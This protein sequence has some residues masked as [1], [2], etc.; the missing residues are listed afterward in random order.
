M[1]TRTA[2]LLRPRR[3]ILIVG[4]VIGAIV[5]AGIF[6]LL[7]GLRAPTAGLLGRGWDVSQAKVDVTVRPDA[8]V[9]VREQ[10]HFRVK[11]NAWDDVYAPVS[12]GKGQVD[13]VSLENV[14]GVALDDENHSTPLEVGRDVFENTQDRPGGGFRVRG[15]E[16]IDGDAEERDVL[17]EY[18]VRKAVEVY[19]DVVFVR[20]VVRSGDANAPLDR[21]DASVRLEAENGTTVTP[22]RSWVH[23]ASLGVETEDRSDA[24]TL[25]VKSIPRDEEIAISA[26][27]PREGAIASTDEAVVRKGDGRAQIEAREDRLVAEEG[28]GLATFVWTNQLPL[29]GLVLLLAL[30]ATTALVSVGHGIRRRNGVVKSDAAGHVPE[31]V[32]PATAFGL[33][34]LRGDE[35]TIVL[36]TL[37]DL[38]DRGFFTGRL[39][40]DGDL[41]LARATTRPVVEKLTP[42]ESAVLGFF[43]R[44][45]G[46]QTRGL[47]DLHLQVPAHEASVRREW[48]QMVKALEETA[49]AELPFERDLRPWRKRIILA[50]AV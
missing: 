15:L 49:I 42:G 22:I 23:P 41:V 45:L 19:D 40:P 28:G 5:G 18:K 39:G 31:S 6:S 9:G 46:G 14:S 21:L 12:P 13:L 32:L 36:P 48:E 17:L 47:A 35:T 3:P 11:K 25:V 43:G 44:R 37:L 7:P 24:A 38:L 8:T 26:M 33:A 30:G 27:F 16:R 4:M 29:A 50:G 2:P 10:L 1:S 20:W 34:A